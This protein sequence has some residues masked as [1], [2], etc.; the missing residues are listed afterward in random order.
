MIDMILDLFGY[1]EMPLWLDL[2][3]SFFMLVG[4]FAWFLIAMLTND[5]LKKKQIFKGDTDGE[6]FWTAESFV[7]VFL[8]ILPWVII[9]IYF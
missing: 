9:Y 8:Y 1:D 7:F 3:I 5:Y 6:S 2:T 4:V